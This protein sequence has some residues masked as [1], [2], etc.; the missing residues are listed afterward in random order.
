[1]R[2][3]ITGCNGLLGQMLNVVATRRRLD[4][5]CTDKD[6]S[7]ILENYVQ[8][9]LTDQEAVSLTCER[10]NPDII[11]NCAAIT[12]VDFCEKDK[13]LASSVNSE[14]P[15]CL[16]KSSNSIGAH[17]IHVSTDYVFDGKKGKYCEDDEPSPINHYGC[18]KLLGEIYVKSTAKNWSIARTSVL[19]GWGREKRPNFATW[20][21]NGLRKRNR[22]NVITDQ[23]ASPTFNVNL[24]EMLLELAERRLQ[25][26]YHLAGND[27][28][29]RFSMAVR[30]AE[31][32]CLDRTLLTP[33]TSDDL[34][35][36]AR[37]PRDSSLSV[38]KAI[39]ELKSTPMGLDTA[40]EEM[41]LSE[42]RENC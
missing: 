18:S 7:A 36:F 37:R 20:I 33:V 10:L 13:E 22:L 21:V 16:A 17:L 1:M 39:R 30:I 8:L 34:N 41:K 31:E 3:L 40:L 23:F 6:D 5:W 4:I 27:R 11:I 29:D 38:D 35:W 9:D 28:I 32:F 2:I 19:Y 25:G 12:D 14:A 26:I 24:A 42:N 15:L